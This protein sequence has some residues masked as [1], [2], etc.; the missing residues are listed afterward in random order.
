MR[1]YLILKE[2][3]RAFRADP[4]VQAAWEA[5]HSPQLAEPTVAPGEGWAELLADRTAFEE[6]DVEGAGER[7]K[8]YSHLD[9]LAIEHLLGAR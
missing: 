1:T 3:A 4:E 2:R 9:Q 5:A 8:H 7:A 6:F